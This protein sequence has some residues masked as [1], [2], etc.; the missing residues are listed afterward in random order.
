MTPEAIEG[1]ERAEERG[2][3]AACLDVPLDILFRQIIDAGRFEGLSEATFA[4]AWTRG[5]NEE[6]ER[7]GHHDT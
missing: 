1:I 2:R 7:W 5:Y 3:S 6:K 4:K